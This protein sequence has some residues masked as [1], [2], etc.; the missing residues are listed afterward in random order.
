VFVRPSRR[1]LFVASAFVLVATAFGAEGAVPAG[2]QTDSTTQLAPGVDHEALSLADPAQ[3]VHVA[4]VAPGAARL[5]AVSS[6]DAVAHQGTGGELP[7]DMCRRVGCYAGVNADFRDSAGDQPVG[8][9]VSGGR[10]VRSPVPGRAQLIVTRDGRLQAGP[11]EWSGSLTA[12]DNRSVA[13]GGINVDPRAGDVTLY[14]PAWGGVTPDGADTELIV[15]SSGAIGAIGATTPVDIVGLRGDP[16]PIP[17]DTAVLAAS[18]SAAATLHALADRADAGQIS[19]TLQLRIRTTID[20]VESVGGSPV[21]VRGGQPAFPDVDDSFTRDR[22]PRSLV[23]WNGAGEVMLVTVDGGRDGASGMTLGEAAELLTGLGATDGFGFDNASATFVAGGDVQNLPV[24]DGPVPAEGPEVAPGHVERPAIN[25]LMVV[26][27]QPDPPPPATNPGS[28]TG[29]GAGSGS[30]SNAGAGTTPATAA[31]G[32]LTT[33]GGGTT[34]AKGVVAAPPT[35]AGGSVL[36]ANISDILSNPAT[37]RPRRQTKPGKGKKTK[38][39]QE[40]V[41]G[42]PSIPDWNDITAALTPEAI[43]A[44]N[45]DSELSLGAGDIDPGGRRH[46]DLVPLTLD[47]L[48]GGMIL[49]VLWG[50]QRARQESRPRPALWL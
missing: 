8:G 23:G 48:A 25:A 15:R 32:K 13:I 33:A 12:S 30:G 5:V 21:L 37:R 4:R 49:T 26:A 11:L 19:R 46:R 41:A 9:V 2:Y 16:G 44:G 1:L 45:G 47:A 40:E 17:A 10:L 36:P 43:A 29:S 3:S 24:D 28:G 7:S 6:H 42:D 39:G 14:T 34:P 20:A 18:G 50:L 35:T 38:D 22:H 27:K 31:P